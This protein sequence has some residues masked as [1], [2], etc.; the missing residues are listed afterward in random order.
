MMI[1]ESVGRGCH[2]RRERHGMRHGGFGARGGFG[3]GGFSVRLPMRACSRASAKAFLRSATPEKTAEMAT[4][5]KSTASASSR[6]IV[7][8]PVPGGP[9][10]IIEDNRPAATIRPIAPSGPVI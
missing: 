6:A 8:L 1:F 4:K 7:V 5:R 2:G 3:A 10:R 9:H